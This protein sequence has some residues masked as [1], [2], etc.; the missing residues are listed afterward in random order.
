MAMDPGSILRTML[1]ASS[2]LL[3]VVGVVTIQSKFDAADRKAAAGVV[4]DY[5]S[6]AGW[7]IPEVI[8]GMHPGRAAQWNVSTESACMQHERVR[9]DVDG[10][11]YE[12]LVDINGPAIHP[13]NPASV[14]VLKGLDAPRAKAAPRPPQ[15]AASGASNSA[16]TSGAP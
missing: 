6:K 4:R 13:G 5:R 8:E 1:I 11:S 10:K 3:A 2:T 14:Q 15:G 12:F 16:P 7:T 9:V